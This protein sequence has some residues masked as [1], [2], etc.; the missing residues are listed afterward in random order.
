MINLHT[1]YDS[2]L[3]ISWFLK[4]SGYWPLETSNDLWPLMK[5]IAFSYQYDKSI[6][7]VWEVCIYFYLEISCLQVIC[8]SCVFSPP[9]TSYT[10]WTLFKTIGYVVDHNGFTWQVWKNPCFL[11]GDI[12][13]TRVLVYG[14]WWPHMAF[15]LHH[16]YSDLTYG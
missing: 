1:K 13:F 12:V 8:K 4:V 16:R 6:Y 10:L 5:T 9:V 7:Q 14:L 2:C 15:E 11:P 3:K